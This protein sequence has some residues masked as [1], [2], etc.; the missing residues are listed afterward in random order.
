MV[1]PG[2]QVYD[3]AIS[4]DEDWADELQRLHGR[5][6]GRGLV[7]RRLAVVVLIVVILVIVIVLV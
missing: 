7:L 5:S 6:I 1:R 4:P 2:S 3:A